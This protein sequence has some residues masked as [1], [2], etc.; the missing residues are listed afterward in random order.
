[1]LLFL[2]RILYEDERNLMRGACT[3]DCMVWRWCYFTYRLMPGSSKSAS[4]HNHR[5]SKVLIGIIDSLLQRKIP[6][7]RRLYG[8]GNQ[9]LKARIVMMNA[10]AENLLKSNPIQTLVLCKQ[11]HAHT[12]IGRWSGYISLELNY[13]CATWMIAWNVCSHSSSSRLNIEY[14]H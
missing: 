13:K 3:Q 5:P 14:Q 6:S 4:T 9:S 2:R 7:V 1:M 10:N 11:S 8:N 12:H